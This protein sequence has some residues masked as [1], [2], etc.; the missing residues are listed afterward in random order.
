MRCPST[1]I[2]AGFAIFVISIITSL[3]FFPNL[4][5]TRETQ[6]T[7]MKFQYPAARRDD[8]VVDDYHGVK[9]PGYDRLLHGC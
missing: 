6:K 8:S 3:N 2:S 4:W 9:V 7:K 1:R 5:Q